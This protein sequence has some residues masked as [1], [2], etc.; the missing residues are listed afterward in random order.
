VERSERAE[1][2][3]QVEKAHLTREILSDESMPRGVWRQMHTI[4]VKLDRMT[5]PLRGRRSS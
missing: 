1:V 3:K 5:R 4:R 2:E